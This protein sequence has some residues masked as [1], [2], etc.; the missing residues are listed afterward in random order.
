MTDPTFTPEADRELLA[1]YETDEEAS[2][3]RSR[4]IDAGIPEDEI[5]IGEHLDIVS[6]LRA[7]MHDELAN[8]FV[9][10]NAAAVYPKESA[11]GMSLMAAVG[12]ALGIVAAFPLAAID[13]GSSYWTRWIVWAVVMVGF[14]L[15]VAMVAGAALGTRRPNEPNAAE[16]GVVLRVE[17]DSEGLRRLLGELHPIRLD[18]VAHDGMPIANV[19]HEG[20]RTIAEQVAQTAGDVVANADSDDYEPTDSSDSSRTADQP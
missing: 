17:H 6:A 20:P 14:G 4:L 3:V 13:V 1:V 8:A 15:S 7:E 18:E 2:R 10:P 19:S 16:R 11:V 12:S 9:V 5:H